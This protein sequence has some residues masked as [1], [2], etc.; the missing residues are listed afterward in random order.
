MRPS[1]IDFCG[2]SV[3][4]QNIQK[5]RHRM[6]PFCQWSVI[7]HWKNLL[8]FLK[9]SMRLTYSVL[10]QS[11]TRL[12]CY[13]TSLSQSKCLSLFSWHTLL[14]RHHVHSFLRRCVLPCVYRTD[15]RSHPGVLSYVC[16]RSLHGNRFQSDGGFLIAKQQLHS[17]GLHSALQALCTMCLYHILWLQAYSLLI[18]PQPK[19]GLARPKRPAL[20]PR[21]H[22]QAG[23]LSGHYTGTPAYGPLCANMT[24]AIKPVWPEVQGW[25]RINWTICFYS[26]SSVFLQQNTFKIC[27]WLPSSCKQ[28]LLLFTQQ[29]WQ[30]RRTYLFNHYN[31][32]VLMNL[33]SQS[34]SNTK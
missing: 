3:S 21:L 16:G 27:P 23:W 18:Q 31:V 32:F 11:F 9:E 4:A 24:S 22:H 7:I 17:D 28:N 14:Q 15:L 34:K 8:L 12:L 6:Q 10:M 19:H 33:H 13:R 2:S 30:L 20:P 25:C 5:H 29:R 1:L 26:P